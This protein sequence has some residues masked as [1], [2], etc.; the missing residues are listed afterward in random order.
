MKLYSFFPSEILTKHYKSGALPL[1]CWYCI[2]PLWNDSSEVLGRG[3][4][5]EFDDQNFNYLGIK[6]S[7][8]KR[9]VSHTNAC[10][11]YMNVDFK[12]R[13]AYNK[14]PQSGKGCVGFKDTFL[15]ILELHECSIDHI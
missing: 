10:D 15:L 11:K 2:S 9:S 1:K 6:W 8:W 3:V 5:N 7:H 4:E 12:L 13:Y 14:L